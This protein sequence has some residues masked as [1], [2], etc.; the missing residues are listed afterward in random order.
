MDSD[1]PNK[2]TQPI[3]PIVEKLYWVQIAITI[4]M[5]ISAY[6]L[7]E[8]GLISR[9]FGNDPIQQWNTR[10]FIVLLAQLIITVAVS[11]ITLKIKTEKTV[12]ECIK[13]P[14]KNLGTNLILIFLVFGL[15]YML[16]IG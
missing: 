2:N 15:T 9:V 8:A 3:E 10:V 1:S 16:N 6:Y 14:I 12:F 11:T 7:F 4:I 13:V 5:G